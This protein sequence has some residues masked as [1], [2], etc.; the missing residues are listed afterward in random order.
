MVSYAWPIWLPGSPNTSI[1]W[2]DRWNS[3][4][5]KTPDAGKR[6]S[7]FSVTLGI[8]PDYISEVVG[9]RVDGVSPDRPGD[10]AGLLAGDV[11]KKMDKYEIDDIYAYMNALGKFRKG[12]SVVVV[13]ERD[14][15]M[16][17]L[18]VVFE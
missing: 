4:K 3:R 8:M 16:V 10:R 18:N 1:S 13:V 9:L 14:G 11:I 5:Q 17:D 15:T 7:S 12:D 6:Q 2:K